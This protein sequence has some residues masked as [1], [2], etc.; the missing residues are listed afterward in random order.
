MSDGG[1]TATYYVHPV[2]TGALPSSIEI[3]SVGNVS[4]V[5]RRV[6]VTANSSPG[7]QIFGSATVIGL[8]GIT[9]AGNAQIHAV[10]ATNGDL[11]LTNNSKQCG[12]ASVG[13]GQIPD[14]EPKLGLLLRLH[15]L[16]TARG[17]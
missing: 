15:A 11:V 8:N 3:V 17:R 4:G 16:P 14:P 9:T 13:L 7:Q 10:A 6:D 12:H 5:T 1:G 2:Y